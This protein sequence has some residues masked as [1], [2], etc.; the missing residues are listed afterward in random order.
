[1]TKVRLNKYLA[2]TGLASRRQVDELINQQRISVNGRPAVLG[3]K[4]DPEKDLIKFDTRVVSQSPQARQELVYYKVYKPVGYVSTSSD[5]ASRPTV[6]SLVKAS[7][8]IYPVGRLDQDSEGLVL[9]TNDGQLTYRLTHPRFHV[10]KE[11]VVWLSGRLTNRKIKQLEAGIEL[12]EGRT[13]PTQVELLAR[14]KKGAVIKIVLHEGMN[15][16]IRRMIGQVGLNV[17]RLKRT[18][19]GPLE[20]GELE[21]GESQELTQAE[22]DQLKELVNY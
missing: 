11:Y 21:P 13:Q 6:V 9:L 8:R 2:Q 17:D 16:Q 22:H 7:E 10:A 1:M 20:I 18:K 3:E 14:H 12:K 4:V 15:R 5:P 19:I